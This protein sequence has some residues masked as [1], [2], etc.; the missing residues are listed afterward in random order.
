MKHAPDFSLEGKPTFKFE[1]DIE[2]PRA[3]LA[4][5]MPLHLSSGMGDG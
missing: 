1:C 5:K 3:E 4:A 2:I